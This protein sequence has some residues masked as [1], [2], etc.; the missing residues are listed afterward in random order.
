MFTGIGAVTAAP[1]PPPPQPTTSNPNKTSSE[2]KSKRDDLMVPLIIDV[3]FS[4]IT[5]I[6]KQSYGFNL[7]VKLPDR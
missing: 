4:A 1:P 3:S 6:P 7:P 5:L 2:I